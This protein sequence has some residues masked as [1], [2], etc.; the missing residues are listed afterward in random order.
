MEGIPIFSASFIQYSNKLL[1]DIPSQHSTIILSVRLPRVI[2]GFLVGMS[3]AA[4][5]TCLQAVFRNP[6]ADPY[7]IGISSGASL[8]AALSIV[9]GVRIVALGLDWG[10]TIFAFAGA[11][12]SVY[13][14]YSIARVGGRVPTAS[15]LLAGVAVA[16]F[17]SAGVYLLML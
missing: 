2:L 3:L 14:V 11:L 6:M 4:V 5:G 17:L 16:A 9:L 13:M 10:T 1:Q 15:L 12:A 7:I 8:G